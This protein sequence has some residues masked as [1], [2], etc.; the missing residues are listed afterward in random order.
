MRKRNVIGGA[1]A[2]L[3]AIGTLV[4]T[5][6]AIYERQSPN[7]VIIAVCLL[8]VFVGGYIMRPDE[9][10]RIADSAVEHF[11][12]FSSFSRFGR[13]KTDP[14]VVLAPEVEVPERPEVTNHDKG[15]I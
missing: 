5:G 10:E 15:I 1:T 8:F 3:G 11:T 6:L 13:R 2:L 4:E 12:P 9:T 7:I 14:V